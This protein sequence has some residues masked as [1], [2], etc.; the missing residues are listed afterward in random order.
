MVLYIFLGRMCDEVFSY[1]VISMF[2]SDFLGLFILG[3]GKR[4]GEVYSFFLDEKREN[5]SIIFFN[6]DFFEEFF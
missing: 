5:Y 2:M 4:W 3:W 1:M 6:L